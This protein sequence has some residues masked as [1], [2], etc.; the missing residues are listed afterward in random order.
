[1][2]SQDVQEL[3]KGL[4]KLWEQLAQEEDLILTSKGK[5]VAIL[6]I[7]SERSSVAQLTAVRRARAAAEAEEILAA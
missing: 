1:M 5:P 2:R 4:S 3:G 7:A 6:S